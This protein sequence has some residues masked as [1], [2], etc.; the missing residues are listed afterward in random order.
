VLLTLLHDRFIPLCIVSSGGSLLPNGAVFG[1]EE[2]TDALELLHAAIGRHCKT[3]GVDC[4]AFDPK[5]ERTCEPPPAQTSETPADSAAKHDWAKVNL[6]NYLY[7]V[8]WESFLVSLFR[9]SADDATLMNLIPVFVPGHPVLHTDGGPAFP[10]LCKRIDRQRTSCA[11]HMESKVVSA[12]EEIKE[13]VKRLLYGKDISHHMATEIRDELLHKLA[14][15][16]TNGGKANLN[17]KTRK[18]IE[19]NFG[20]DM[21]MSTNSQAFRNFIFTAWYRATSLLEQMFGRW[22]R[23]RS[24]SLKRGLLYECMADVFAFVDLQIKKIANNLLKLQEAHKFMDCKPPKKDKPDGKPSTFH[25]WQNQVNILPSCSFLRHVGNKAIVSLQRVEKE[26]KTLEPVI[27]V[28]ITDLTN[29]LWEHCDGNVGR[30]HIIFFHLHSSN[31]LLVDATDMLVSCKLELQ[32]SLLWNYSC[33]GTG[34]QIP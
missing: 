32:G 7:P 12:D 25:R 34:S 21:A 15:N 4:S 10:A 18:W 13:M 1:L 19:A 24:A 29:F 6:R 26:G 16:G 27:I 20:T 11:K 22:K 30:F 33:Y 31:I 23:G 8:E 9:D 2:S 28:H 14:P 3:H 17:S 5:S